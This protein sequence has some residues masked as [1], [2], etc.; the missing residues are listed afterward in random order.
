MGEEK[1]AFSLCDL[2]EGRVGVVTEVS[3]TGDMKR[4]FMDLGVV[5]DT[6]IRCLFKSPYG[7][8]A[9]Y[10]IRGTIIAIRKEDAKNVK[11]SIS[12]REG[13]VD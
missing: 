7:D 2:Q 8:P 12:D 9:A 4:R 13:G 1:R 3:S 10:E 6:N 5:P 11:I